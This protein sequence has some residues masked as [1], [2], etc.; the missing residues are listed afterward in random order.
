MILRILRSATNVALRLLVVASFLVL[1][2]V[3]VGPRFVDYRPLTVLSGSMKPAFGPGDMVIVEPTPVDRLE[4]GDVISYQA[5]VDDKH[6]VTHRIVEI[7]RRKP[8]VVVRT[9]GDS[10]DAR[11]PWTAALHGPEAWRVRA[12]VPK[13]GLA[14]HV[15]RQRPVRLLALYVAPALLVLLWLVQ[16]WQR[17]A[18]DRQHATAEIAPT[19]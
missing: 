3:G 14:I 15:L 9:K 1:I 6:V 18:R 12:A 17:P 2:A 16:I 13:A 4:V 8:D 19:A 10:N 5:P 11:D 7:V